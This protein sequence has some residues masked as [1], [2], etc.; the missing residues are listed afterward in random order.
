[1]DD[2][3]ITVLSNIGMISFIGLSAY[4][5][6]VTGEISFGQ[7]AYF[8]LGAYAAGAVTAML[9]LPIWVG[10]LAGACVAGAIAM[11]VGALTLRLSGL[12]FSISTLAFAEMVRLILL[13]VHVQV[14]VEGELVGPAGAEGFHGIRWMFER[15][16]SLA[17]FMLLIYGL[18]ALVL[19]VLLLIERSRLGSVFR[20]LGSDDL[21]AEMQGLDTVRYRILAAGMAGA[22]AGI[23]GALYAHFT[24]YVEP[25]FFNV[26]LG[27]HALAYGLIGGLGTAFGPFIGVAIDI[28]FLE[29]V[30]FIQ[31]YRM[32]VF[33]GL[34]AILLIFMPRGI[35][36]EERV[37]RLKTLF[38]RRNH[39]G[40]QRR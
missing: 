9:L 38:R 20:M 37:H 35:L 15:D 1:M 14:E 13:I 39:A 29:A 22:I 6:L 25:Q 19:I 23:G 18:L 16:L 7:H 21:L 27:V 36:D 11:V 4:L 28:G 40:A 10:I 8:G 32:I 24:T 26:M 5:L 34:A 3:V 33:G 31:G 2:Y 17:H 30:R 12:Y